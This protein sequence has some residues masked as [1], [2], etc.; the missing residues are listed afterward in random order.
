MNNVFYNNTGSGYAHGSPSSSG[1]SN[2]IINNISQDNSTN[3]YSLGGGSDV[4]VFIDF[5]QWNGNGTE[6][7]NIA[8]ILQGNNNIRDVS[9]AMTNPGALDFTLQASSPC[10]ET[11][12]CV[13]EY[14]DSDVLSGD[15]WSIGASQ[16]DQASGS[17][18]VFG[19]I[20]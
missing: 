2:F 6:L 15:H 8:G 14:T 7:N 1:V 16:N 4:S 18:D 11:G 5:S 9:S 12:L 13:N 10:L 17:T 19:W 3:G 20:Q